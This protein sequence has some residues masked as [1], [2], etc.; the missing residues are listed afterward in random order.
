MLTFFVL[1]FFDGWE[2]NGKIF[3]GNEDHSKSVRERN[4]ELCNMDNGAAAATTK[5]K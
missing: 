3:P 5:K 4:H 2:M 1:K